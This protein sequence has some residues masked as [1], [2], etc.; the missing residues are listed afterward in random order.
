MFASNESFARPTMPDQP[1]QRPNLLLLWTDEQR[2]DVLAAAAG[3][4]AVRTP[5]LDRL[6]SES[7][8]FRQTYCC[9]PVCTPSRGSILTGLWP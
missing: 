3:D 1:P 7:F 6:A 9:Q 2:A 8:V 5:N 4:P